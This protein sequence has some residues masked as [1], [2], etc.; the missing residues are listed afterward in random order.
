MV[1]RFFRYV[2]TAGL[3]LAGACLFA[4]AYA[5]PAI[6]VSS[7]RLGQH[8]DK[9]RFVLEMSAAPQYDVFLLAEPYRIVIDLPEL[10][11][12]ADEDAGRK[13]G[14]VENYRFGLFKKD[15]S[16]VVL[17][18]GGPVKILRTVILPPSSGKPYRFFIDI[19]KTDE[20]SFR[21]ELA[22]RRS[23]QKNT[24]VAIVAPEPPVNSRKYT[25]VVDAGHGG[26]DPGAI[27]KSGVYEKKITLGVAK[28]MH[29]ILSKNKKY[30]VI[31]TRNDDT[32]LSLRERV[33]VGRHAGADLF[34]SIH[35]DSISRPDFRGST[36][37]TLSENASDDEAAELAKSENKSDL[38]AGVDMSVQDDTVQGILIDLAQRETMNFSV[39]FAEMIIPEI[40]KS[41][42]K[43]RGRSHRFAGFRVLK[44]PDVPS[45]LVELG[46]L[47]NRE[48]EKILKS[49]TGQQ[50]LAQAIVNAIDR[51]FK[52]VDP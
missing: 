27:G 11:W 51:Y 20:A 16:R 1:N 45:V 37:Y 3:M 4:P 48:D 14:L 34:V 5:A 18:V 32:F 19:Q 22:A 41:G 24:Q 12:R 33:A 10:N 46:Y 6:D 23:Q 30:N 50:R 47:S 15:T 28:R 49:G 39:K 38:I 13:K 52:T 40:S 8:T 29:D 36:V 9:T 17:D 25:I 42:M 26:I 21:K 2:L 31:M 35:A 43:T 7:A 44:A